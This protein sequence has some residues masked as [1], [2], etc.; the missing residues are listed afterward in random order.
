MYELD[1]N[2]LDQLEDIAS[3]IQE[4]DELASYLDEEEEEFYLRLKEMFEP[5][6]NLIYDEVAA[7]APLQLIALETVLLNPLFEGLFLPK[8]LGH[9][10]LRGEINE[11]FKYVRPQNHFKEVL[12]AICNSANFDILKKRIGQ[13]IQ[14]GFALSSDIWVTN[15]IN[16]ITNKRVRYYLQ[17]QKLDR[18]RPMDARK[19]GYLRYLKQFTND[20]YH[21]AE[22]PETV[23]EL[24]VMFSPLKNFLIYRIRSR[25]DNT[26]LIPSLKAFLE[27]KSFMNTDEYLQIA[28]LYGSFFDLEEADSKHLAKHLAAIRKGMPEFDEKWLEFVLELHK[29]DDVKLDPQADLRISALL[30]KSVKDQLS[31]FCTLTDLI[32]NQGYM[33]EEVHE[34]VRVF[35]SRH[36]GLSIINECVRAVIYGYFH[37]LISN[38]EERAYPD[39]FEE[40]KLFPVY[41]SIFA[42]QKFNQDLKDLSMNYVTK[43]LKKFTDKR[44]KDYQDVKKFVSTAF[45]D[46]K[47]LKDKE[48]VELFK[49]RRKRKKQEA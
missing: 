38:L 30:D 45:V 22:F 11:K 9:S 48:V 21:T 39:F 40:T 34:A 29:R 19:T 37:R 47:F 2:Y 20:N 5:K 26:S 41:M 24:K 1:E 12:L 27:N 8:I 18:Y 16:S 32:H 33:N 3:E 14:M 10:V 49:T 31:E 35:Y 28:F 6:I 36:E 15:L 46:F 44:G 25:W 13:S 43:L 4:S 42:N 23:S 7:K 17:G